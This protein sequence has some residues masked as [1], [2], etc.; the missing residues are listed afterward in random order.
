MRIEQRT[1]GDD[2]PVMEASDLF[3]GPA[4]ADATRQFLE[5]PGHHILFAYDG[6]NE[7]AV[8]F[9]TGIE[10]THPDKGTEMFL[11]E[12]GVADH[13]RGKGVGKALVSAL[14]DLAR[15]I[16]CYGMWAV[17]ERTNEPA[18]ATYAAAGGTRES[19]PVLVNWTFEKGLRQ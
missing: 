4:R 7:D 8:G 6:D 9:V 14:A 12:L 19:D 3:D 16:G 5:A 10:M 17:T 2:D 18:L 11:Y 15:T 13:A 1:S